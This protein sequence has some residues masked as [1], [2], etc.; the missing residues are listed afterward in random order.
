[1]RE[2]DLI[3]RMC[4]HSG[5]S[6]RTCLRDQRPV[7]ELIA[8]PLGLWTAAHQAP[9]YPA[10]LIDSS[11]YWPDFFHRTTVR[12]QEI[13]RGLTRSDRLLYTCCWGEWGQTWLPLWAAGSRHDRSGARVLVVVPEGDDPSAQL[14]RELGLPTLSFGFTTGW[15][16]WD[17]WARKALSYALPELL[18]SH[19]HSCVYLDTDAVPIDD[20][21]PLF[22]S[23]EANGCWLVEDGNGLSGM[24]G[25]TGW[26][27]SFYRDPSPPSWVTGPI[28]PNMGAFGGLCS[29][30]AVVSRWL[31]A[32]RTAVLDWMFADSSQPREQVAYGSASTMTGGY[33]CGAQG[34]N[35]QLHW[36][37]PHWDA[38]R[39]REFLG[40]TAR[41]IHFSGRG[42]EHTAG[43]TALSRL[44]DR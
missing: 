13:A 4:S 7:R 11:I 8:C 26:L 18:E 33:T 41:V 16:A 29:R 25:L 36:T 38:A 24:Q 44:L 20:L 14:A 2:R 1:M 28:A 35:V 27:A 22:E 6:G 37:G 42:K 9:R 10:P 43:I 23:A 5:D 40:Q 3:C 32:R 31:R 15:P 39:P 17:A 12:W 30:L 34:W 19:C 21:T